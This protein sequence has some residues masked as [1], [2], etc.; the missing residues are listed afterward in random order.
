MMGMRERLCLYLHVTLDRCTRLDVV[1]P[2]L[3]AIFS[4]ACGGKE[5]EETCRHFQ[6]G[7]RG[8][9]NRCGTLHFVFQVAFFFTRTPVRLQE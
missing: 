5:C 8:V 9:Y 4:M 3:V 1:W 6:H 7:M 2:G